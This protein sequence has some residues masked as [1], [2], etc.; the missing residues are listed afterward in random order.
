[1]ICRTGLQ[2]PLSGRIK[3]TLKMVSTASLLG[4]WHLWKVVENKPVSSLV[5]FL[6]KALNRTNSLLCERQVAQM[7]WKGKLPCERGHPVQ[8][9]AIPFAFS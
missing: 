8:N 6:S 9:I 5:V 7:P 4:V 2:F 1:M 3:T